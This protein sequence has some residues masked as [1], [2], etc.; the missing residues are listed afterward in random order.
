MLMKQS[1]LNLLLLVSS[2]QTSQYINLRFVFLG[3]KK[4]TLLYDVGAPDAD[5][6]GGSDIYCEVCTTKLLLYSIYG[7]IFLTIYSFEMGLREIKEFSQI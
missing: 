4:P 3:K 1:S 2:T 7:S 6:T 5:R